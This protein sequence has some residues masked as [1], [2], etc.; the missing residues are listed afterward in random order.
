MSRRSV[1]Q[2]NTLT[3]ALLSA[4]FMAAG[5]AMAA[6]SLYSVFDSARFVLVA[7]AAIGAGASIAVVVDRMGRGGLTALG[8]S[9]IAYLGAGLGLAI[10]GVLQGEIPV[11]TALGELVRG[12]I[13]GWKDIVTLPLPLGV[14]GATLVPVL[15]M[16]LGG[17][18]LSTWIAVR[19]RRRWGLAAAVTVVMVVTAILVGPALRAEPLSHVLFEIEEAGE[20]VKLTVTHGG[21]EPD[22]Q[23][24]PGISNGWPEII[25]SLKTLLETGE[26]LPTA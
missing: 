19:A 4:G 7:A 25:A 9:L 26:P 16:L 13:A 15:A 1:G 5:A 14:Y 6:V 12:P 17:T 22:S 24:L 20:R 21:F 3:F 11:L 2:A 23:I 18:L 8:L 10:P